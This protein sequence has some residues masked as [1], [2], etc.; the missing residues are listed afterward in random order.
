M[1]R[2]LRHFSFSDPHTQLPYSLPRK[3]TN[4]L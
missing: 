1:L 2:L 4:D 3:E